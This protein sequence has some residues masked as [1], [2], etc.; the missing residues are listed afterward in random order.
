MTIKL[1]RLFCK[2]VFFSFLTSDFVPN[3]PVKIDQNRFFGAS[4]DN[5]ESPLH[6]TQGNDVMFVCFKGGMGVPGLAPVPP[7]SPLCL[8]NVQ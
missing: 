6:S 7:L 2:F 5:R 8:T 3:C 1:L 4:S